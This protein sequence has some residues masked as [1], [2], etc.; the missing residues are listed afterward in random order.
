MGR[1]IVK[2]F[3]QAKHSGENLFLHRV[4]DTKNKS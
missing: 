4:L 3:G 2:G 1:V